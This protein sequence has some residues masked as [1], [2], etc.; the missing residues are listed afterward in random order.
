MG[1]EG[2]LLDFTGSGQDI[3]ADCYEHGN[4]PSGSIQSWDF[5]DQVSDHHL[6]KNG[7]DW[8]VT[9][10]STEDSTAH[11][12][13]HETSSYVIIPSTF[14]RYMCSFSLLCFCDISQMGDYSESIS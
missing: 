11:S 6:L 13:L 5:C 8:L 3:V 4:V 12:C 9:W 7:S 2:F 14:I 1:C 10:A